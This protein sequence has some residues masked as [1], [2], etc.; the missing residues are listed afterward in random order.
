M[1]IWVELIRFSQM[2]EM[3]KLNKERIENIMKRNPGRLNAKILLDSLPIVPTSNRVK[4]LLQKNQDI[5]K[6]NL[7]RNFFNFEGSVLGHDQG[8]NPIQNEGD[9]ETGRLLKIA[10][11]KY[12]LR[13]PQHGA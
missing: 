11:A 4:Q 9:Q 7:V 12:C 5:L 3:N 1:L 8:G 2:A 13:D 10:P 6:E